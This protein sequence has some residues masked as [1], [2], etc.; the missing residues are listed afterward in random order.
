M[1]GSRKTHIC[2]S[3]R[4]ISSILYVMLGASEVRQAIVLHGSTAIRDGCLD[5]TP[6]RDR[7]SF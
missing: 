6:Q 4:A 2:T 1:R 7:S 3:M 5:R